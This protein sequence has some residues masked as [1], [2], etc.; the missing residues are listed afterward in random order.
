MTLDTVLA[1]DILSLDLMDADERCDGARRCPLN[2]DES[3]QRG[4]RGGKLG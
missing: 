3:R 4:K 2:I 1:L